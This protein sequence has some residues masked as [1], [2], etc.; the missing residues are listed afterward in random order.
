MHLFVAELGLRCRTGLFF[1]CGE[2]RVFFVAVCG[3]LVAVAWASGVVAC[4]LKSCSS[5][6][7]KYR[8]I[9]VAHFHSF[10]TIISSP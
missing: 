8:L 9:A 4:G 10:L 1:S 6:A 2:W 3:V 7:L 5:Q